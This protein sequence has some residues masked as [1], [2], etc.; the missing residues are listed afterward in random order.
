MISITEFFCV[1]RLLDL[2][3]RDVVPNGN[4]I[5]DLIW[6]KAS[7]GAV[8]TWQ[9]IQETYKSWYNIKPSWT[10]INQVL[11]VRNAIAH[12]LGQLTR[13]QQN[14]RS[15][16]VGKITTAGFALNGNRVV[17]EEANL[18]EVKRICIALIT[19]VD[20]KVQIATGDVS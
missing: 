16:T 4:V 11:Q 17:I 12:G 18:V 3:E 14:T 9:A 19:E 7:A 20:S 6:Q 13:V 2:A 1:D 10:E 5:R 8:G 15:A